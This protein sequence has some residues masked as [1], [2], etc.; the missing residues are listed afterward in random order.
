MRHVP[1]ALYIDT[2]IFLKSK[3]NIS[4]AIPG[5]DELKSTFAKSSLRLLVPKM[6]ERELLRHFA[7]TAD[8]VAKD[9]IKAHEEYL[10]N[11]LNITKLP[12]EDEL[13]AKC[14]MVMKRNWKS[15][16]EHFVV[17]N[18][19]IVGN[20]ENVVDWYFDAH[21]PFRETKKSKEFPDAFIISALDQYHKEW[22]ANI[23]IISKD[24]DFAKAC[25]V[26]RHF[27]HFKSLEDYIE[28]FNLELSGKER[29]PSEANLSKLITTEDLA[30]LKSL[31][32]RGGGVTPIEIERVIK[33]LENGGSN[34]DYF[35]QNAK[36]IIWLKHLLE[37]G[38]FSS[39]PD[40][41]YTGE[42]NNTLLHWPPLNY[43]LNIFEAKPAE[44][45]DILSK[46]PQT[47]NFL[48]LEG[49]FKIALK[50]D[51]ADSLLRL[52]SFIIAFIENYQYN[53][54]LLI[55]LLKKPYI[56]D[57]RL[58]KVTP[59]LLLKIVEFRKDHDEQTKISQRQEDSEAP[60][61]LLR[62]TPHMTQ[63]DYQEVLEK[64]VCVLVER[65]PYKVTRILIDAVASMVRLGM[66]PDDFERGGSEDYSEV[67]CRT[68]DGPVQGNSDIK[69]SLVHTLT[70]A[71]TQVYDKAPDSIYA[72][73]QSLRN[74]RWKIFER[75]RQ[76]LYASYPSKQTLPW[77]REYILGYGYYSR[78]EYGYEFQLMLRKASEHFGFQLLTKDEL[79]AIFVKILSGPPKE[80]FRERMG[81][82][83][84][85]EHFQQHL[86]YF[87]YM[88]LRPFI[89]VLNDDARKY[90]NELE[91]R[92]EAITD[93][94]YSPYGPVTSGVVKSQSPKSNEE[95]GNLTD[96]ELLSYLNDWDEEHR[97]KDNWLVE[98]NIS[99]L[100][101]VFQYQ[102]KE[103][104]ITD[105]KRQAF[106]LTNCDQIARP[107]YVTAILKVMIELVKEKNFDYLNQSIDFC[108]WVLSHPDISKMEGQPELREES[109]DY[110]YWGGT[111][112]F[113]VDFIDACVSKDTDVSISI[114]SGLARLLNQVCNQSDWRLDH[115][116]P[117]FLSQNNPIG[118][119][120]NN[121][122]SRALEALVDFGFWVRRK[123][124][125]DNLPEVIST[126]ERRL[127]HNAEVP[128]T[129]PEHALL[130]MLFGKLCILNSDW[131][132]QQQKKI[133]AL[134]SISNWHAA[135]S[136]YIRYNLPSE[137]I[138]NIMRSE[139]E[140]AIDNLE[141][142]ISEESANSDLIE[143]LGQHLFIY[144]LWEVYPLKGRT[145]LL[146]RFYDK[147][148]NKRNY[149]ASLFKHIGQLL[150]NSGK[151]LDN[152]LVKR[153]YDFVDW[154]LEA[155]ETQELQEF[156][157]WLNI[158]CLEPDWRLSS[159][160]KTLECGITKNTGFSPWLRVLTELCIDY[161][162]L[163]LECFLKITKIMLQG[164]QIYI[165][166]DEVKSIL[167]IGLN[168]EDDNI[169]ND[170]ESA[171]DNLLK[172]GHFRYLDLQ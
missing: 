3:E 90:F 43:L 105:V 123:L 95:L 41:E 112:R 108:E 98:I 157:F 117:V 140:Y 58:S 23:A 122:R 57:P 55:D 44:V 115:E 114:R 135:F 81:E 72:L 156:I 134:K 128:L 36:D 1:T 56:L 32:A 172:L 167:K 158:E 146:E 46:L 85:E 84:S 161:P 93:D 11:I 27:M 149:L 9:V 24:N 88:Q 33:L 145:S 16:K 165:T 53:Y 153:I 132:Y 78:R 119:A 8:K 15:F 138:F 4:F 80:D 73:D 21:P 71:C 5:L 6:M 62:P 77:I 49:I 116:H 34:H 45:I 59:T 38:Y 107:I 101:D 129:R 160:S 91:D 125:E 52:Y 124:P 17:E 141:I 76:R 30:E 37:K 113:V 83:Y 7:R 111:R 50:A 120:I 155:A 28:R 109:R 70:Y 163:V 79:E 144:Y 87:H 99:A 106:W 68:L 18:L 60:D 67:W 147:I 22:H 54:K 148:N 137:L 162:A 126:I 47:K 13:K 75:L 42:G 12:C 40:A 94:S 69:E 92:V 127:S 133:F 39:V 19:P 164:T 131:I 143:R 152:V 110:P 10:I 29:P 74:H 66:H 14:I 20:V 26:R 96:E 65:E 35:F 51:S 154:R 118:E 139:F 121:T 169:R 82:Q 102:F 130:G 100:A 25:E 31:L 166:V 150:R 168:N 103:K 64:G 136:S 171:K 48:V 89:S 151:K 104:I 61:T 86:S 159:F 2:C 97:D 63:W 142:L 170:A